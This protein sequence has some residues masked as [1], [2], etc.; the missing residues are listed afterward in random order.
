MLL[1]A[2]V[3]LLAACGGREV[4]FPD[5]LE[6]LETN[7]AVF[8]EDEAEILAFECGAAG[9]WDFCHA[10]G[11]VHADVADTWDALKEPDVGVDRRRV[12]EWTVEH[13]VED[14]YDV[15]YR[16]HT[17]VEDLV[18]VEYDLTWRQGAVDDDIAAIRWQKTE[19]S[20]LVEVLEGSVVLEQQ[21]DVT[22]VE[23]V[24]H[25]GTPAANDV[26]NM[27]AYLEDLHRSVVAWT[28]GDELPT[29]D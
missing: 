16:V 14:G 2:T 21:G 8:P 25:L 11:F 6:P 27:Q 26:E 12:E 3:L 19:G 4:P 13:D 28:R 29:Y 20:S 17:R 22:A 18:T 15:S 5:G 24:Q 23:I 9:D 1:R 10:R 7:T